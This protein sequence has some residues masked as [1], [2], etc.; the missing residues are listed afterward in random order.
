MWSR[1]VNKS[2]SMLPEMGEDKWICNVHDG[3]SSSGSSTHRISA[4]HCVSLLPSTRA[5]TP[6]VFAA[7]DATGSLT[8]VFILPS[9]AV[10]SSPLSSPSCFA[11]HQASRV[12]RHMILQGQRISHVKC[13]PSLPSSPSSHGVVITVAS[14]EGYFHYCCCLACVFIN[15]HRKFGHC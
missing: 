11:T 9:L 12:S 4:I 10:S 6:S 15:F 14:F 1:D 5:V 13:F 8:L 3:G 7:A 2:N